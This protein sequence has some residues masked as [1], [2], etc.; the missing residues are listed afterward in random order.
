MPFGEFLEDFPAVLFVATHVLMV[1]IGIWAIVR[2]RG[3]SPVIA[4]AMWLYVAS[5][6]LFLAFWAGLIT[7]K[8][9]AVTEQT[10]MMAMVIW[11]VLGTQRAASRA[12]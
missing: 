3:R 10:L 6:P 9:T 4:S 8:M 2:T 11:L 1:A 5:Q 7:L 12:V